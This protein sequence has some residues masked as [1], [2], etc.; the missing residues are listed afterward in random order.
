MNFNETFWLGLGLNSQ[1]KESTNLAQGSRTVFG[2]VVRPNEKK[3]S[4]LILKEPFEES[5]QNFIIYIPYFLNYFPP[6]IKKGTI[7]NFAVLKLL[8][9]LVSLDTNLGNTV[10]SPEYFTRFDNSEIWSSPAC[11]TSLCDSNKLTSENWSSPA[12]FASL[13]D[14]NKLTH[15][16]DCELELISWGTQ[17]SWLV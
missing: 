14:S 9:Q 10:L 7:Q 17:D 6:Y 8:V 4:S 1:T 13:C 12:C 11:F 16:Y 5:E 3:C 15:P 2:Q